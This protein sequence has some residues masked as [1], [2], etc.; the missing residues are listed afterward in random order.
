MADTIV[1]AGKTYK[2]VDSVTN[3]DSMF[4]GFMVKDAPH[5]TIGL[6]T[7]AY[8]YLE[9]QAKKTYWTSS[10]KVIIKVTN[11]SYPS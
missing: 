4:T 9:I 2:M 8:H 11:N 1:V 10:E 7:E 5:V 6:S 3:T